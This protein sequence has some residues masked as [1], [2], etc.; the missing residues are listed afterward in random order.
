MD[1][2]NS[3]FASSFQVTFEPNTTAAPHP[4]FNQYKCQKK[5]L[6][7]NERRRRILLLQ[8]EK[9]FDYLSNVRKMT[10]N[11]WTEDDDEE[12][13]ENK[14]EEEEM[15]CKIF[16]KKPGKFYRN[17]LM[18]SEWLVEVPADLEEEWLLVVC[19]VGKRCLVVSSRGVTSV[20]T[21]NGYMLHRF[22]TMLPGGN[23]SFGGCNQEATIFDC[24]YNEL[25]NVYYILDIMSWNGYPLYDTHPNFKSKFIALPNF[26]C[27]K[28]IITDALASANFSVDGVLFYHKRTH[29]T[30][31]T[32][33]LVVWLKPYMLPE[34]LDIPV[35][36]SMLA[37]MPVSYS[38]YSEHL[39]LVQKDRNNFY[40]DKQ[41]TENLLEMGPPAKQKRNRGKKKKKKKSSGAQSS[42]MDIVADAT[43]N[44]Q[45][46][47]VEMHQFVA[48]T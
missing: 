7:Q 46:A 14:N 21:K 42:S 4:R 33:P 36:D 38:T 43:A 24:I 32:T 30:F 28:E 11:D 1:E 41:E 47:S 18:L 17:Q 23:R 2:L 40:L 13:M 39:A 34:L 25:E 48:S 16:F 29:Y 45:P 31:G 15:E 44:E 9:R 22:P 3:T 12:E 8:K 6:D 20:Y 19:P 37:N 10:C 35:P 5:I 26:T 27:T